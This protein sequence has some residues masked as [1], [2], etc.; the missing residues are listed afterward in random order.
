MGHQLTVIWRRGDTQFHVGTMETVQRWIECR[1]VFKT[2]CGMEEAQST[3]ADFA[4]P[5]T[6]HGNVMSSEYRRP[7]KPCPDCA[8]AARFILGNLGMEVPDFDG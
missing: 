2:I 5:G 1:H 6:W 4:V 7:V 3:W 8:A